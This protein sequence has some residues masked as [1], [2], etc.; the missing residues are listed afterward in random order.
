MQRCNQIA[1]VIEGWA[2]NRFHIRMRGPVQAATRNAEVAFHICRTASKRAVSHGKEISLHCSIQITDTPR[3]HFAAMPAE[4]GI[5]LDLAQRIANV[6]MDSSVR[7]NDEPGR[8]Q[9]TSA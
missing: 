1:D 6:K 4:A 2:G 9:R 3:F 5:H 7:W 8:T